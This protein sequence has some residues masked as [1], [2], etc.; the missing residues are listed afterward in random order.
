MHACQVI[1]ALAFA[2]RR[3]ISEVVGTVRPGASRMISQVS[4]GVDRGAAA[5]IRNGVFADVLAGS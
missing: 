4:D 1:G 2:T 5:V 3:V